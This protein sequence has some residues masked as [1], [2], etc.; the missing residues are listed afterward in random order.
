M[1]ERDELL[2][3]AWGRRRRIGLFTGPVLFAALLALP[4]P[5]GLAP[6]GWRTAAVGVL[7]AVWWVTEAIPIPAT[8][9]L[10][11]VL[12]PILGAA[13]IDVVATPYANPLLFLFLGGFLLALAIE[14]WGLHRRLA[15]N[16][17][18]RVGTG[19][20]R[21]LAGFMGSA[22]L[23]SMWVSNTATTLMLLPIALSVVEWITADD[24]ASHVPSGFAAALMLGIAYAASIGGLGTLI[25][26]PPNALVGGFL[27]ET[28]GI[29]VGFARWMMVGVPVVVVTIPIAYVILL[30][31]HRIGGVATMA[32][33]DRIAAELSALGRMSRAEKAVGVVFALT[34]L[35][36]VT[37]PLLERWISGI[38]DAGI[39]IAGA[40][41]L[42]VLP[43]GRTRGEFVLDWS[44]ARRVPWGILI[45]FGGGL[46]LAAAIEATGLAE[47][48]GHAMG[49]VETWSLVAILLAVAVVVVFFSELA[50]NTATAAT[51]L[52][53]AGALALALGLDPLVLAIPTGMAASGGF[54]LPVAT[55]PNAIVYAS[56]SITMS[57][58]ARAGFLLDLAFVI[59]VTV[60]CWTLVPL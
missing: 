48:L 19:P 53:I 20:A 9:L 33:R 3:A 24:D 34:A 10:P 22:A 51:F 43:S 44:T 18:D 7:M 49:G 52:P 28:Y 55:A 42:F 39:A 23:I 16:V 21:L 4:A 38:T 2:G 14:R 47:W 15:L 37:R 26:T 56:G 11:I 57:Q 27:R 6:A 60:A 31:S 13:S 46:S 35:A 12:L 29:D 36:W 45:L 50:S 32:G 8:S 54:M 1:P 30:R 40:L 17:I 41:L 59:V 25:G 58:M 5:E